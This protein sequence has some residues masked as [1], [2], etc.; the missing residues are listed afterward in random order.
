MP[1]WKPINSFLPSGVVPA[2]DDRQDRRRGAGSCA[3]GLQARQ[4]ARVRDGQGGDTRGVGPPPSLP[5]AHRTD[6]QVAFALPW[7]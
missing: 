2:G 1:V 3:A 5:R 6:M 7:S 4:A